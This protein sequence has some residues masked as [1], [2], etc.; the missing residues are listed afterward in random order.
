MTIT[1][2]AR[3]V[4]AVRAGLRLAVAGLALAAVGCSHDLPGWKTVTSEHFRVYTDQKPS[5]FE[6]T[7]ERLEDIHA[8]FRQ[9]FFPKAEPPPLEVFL[10]GQAEF[11]DLVGNRSGGMFLGEHGKSGV[12]VLFDGGDPFLIGQMAAHEVAHGFIHAQFRRVPHWYDEGC[13]SYLSSIMVEEGEHR[14]SFGRGGGSDDVAAAGMLVPVMQLFSA[15]YDDYAKGDWARSHYATGW[16]IM[17]YI[18]HGEGK[19]LRARF[20]ILGT[21]LAE[22]GGNAGAGAAAWARVFPEVPLRELD[23]RLRDHVH[24]AIEKHRDSR[25]VFKF[26]RGERAPSRIDP[27]DLARVDEIRG[28]LRAAR[29]PDRI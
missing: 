29:V 19:Q 4:R 6:W 21:A 10:F 26:E 1:P 28:R 24:Q 17:H 13:A 12:L 8:G 3:N 23:D 25:W 15:R 20:D 5:K 14:V 18:G 16:A 9:S 7:V 22:A 2:C 27:A 11:Q